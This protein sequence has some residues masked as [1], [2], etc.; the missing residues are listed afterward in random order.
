MKETI[1]S[2]DDGCIKIEHTHKDA[3]E[4]ALEKCEYLFDVNSKLLNKINKLEELNK[5][6][7]AFLIFIRSSATIED[8][9]LWKRQVLSLSKQI[10]SKLN[11]K[12]D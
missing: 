2:Q 4:K 9:E 3:L 11:E 12:I 8:T 1:K 7:R 5:L 10:C 6:S